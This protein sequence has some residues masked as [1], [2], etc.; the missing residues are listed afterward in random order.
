MGEDGHLRFRIASGAADFE[1]IHR[2][3]YRTFV[4]EIPQH[5]ANPERRLVDRFHAE[6][7]YAVCFAGTELVGMV[8]GRANRPFSLDA[9]VADLDSHLPPGRRPV[10][11]RLLSV[12]PGHR[13]GRIFARL[14]GLL[15]SHFRERGCDLALVS[16]TLGRLRLYRHLGFVPF[17]PIV[18]TGEALFQPMYLTQKEFL[19]RERALAPPGG[20][21]GAGSASFL[22]GPVRV[23]REVRRA[24]AGAPVTHRSGEF[25]D[26]VRAVKRSL[27]ALVGAPAV[28]ILLGSG[29]LANDVVGGQIARFGAPGL[30]LSFGEFGE[31]LED[32]AARWGLRFE[33]VRAPWG[34]PVSVAEVSRRAAALRGARWIWTVHCE[35]STGVL[36]DLPALA[37]AAAEGGLALCLDAV[38]SVGI[39]P[40]DLHGVHLA[41]CSAG[42]GLGSYPGLALV[43]HDGSVRPDPERLPRYLDLGLYAVE[44]GVPFTASSN[45]LHAL[46]AALGRKDWPERFARIAAASARLRALLRE[47][48]L[49]IVGADD[50]ASPAV[51]T[52]ALPAGIDSA[53]VGGT[54]RRR[55]FLLNANSR[56][57]VKRGWVQVCLM[58]EWDDGVLDRVP[59]EL[60]M[61]VEESAGRA[62]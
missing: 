58:G 54:L 20:T 40:V 49:S 4:E 28:E 39:V 62:G 36:L 41:S 56:Y 48:G 8:A 43:F 3:N 7:T 31:R 19:G 29:T 37:A 9:K 22:P 50:R 44:E 6:N 25:L 13:N 32:H 30:V 15:A 61:A 59:S 18:G 1:A 26:D 23:R 21:A 10:E 33:V 47:E 5:P 38:S 34:E 46:K 14:V 17:G 57:L 24:M 27:C 16:G 42:K 35:T 60:R 2:L 51:V 55:G 12:A 53:A 52:V 11:V 45:L